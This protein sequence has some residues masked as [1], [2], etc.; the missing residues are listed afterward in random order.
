MSEP[1]YWMYES[2]GILR[3]VVRA[4][5]RGAQ[6]SPQDV[7]TMRAYLRQ[8][9]FADAWD[10]NPYGDGT[11]LAGLRD[12]I[13]SLNSTAQIREWLRRATEMGMDPL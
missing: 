1:F 4:Y 8:W 6:L 12:M 5:L 11:E 3:P 10:Q 2:S 9:I 7:A 13:Q